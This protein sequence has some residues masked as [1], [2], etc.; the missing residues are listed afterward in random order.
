MLWVLGIVVGCCLDEDPESYTVG[1]PVVTGTEVG[2]GAR[3]EQTWKP[4]LRMGSCN[5]Y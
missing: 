5:A 2:G 3:M 4:G 1:S